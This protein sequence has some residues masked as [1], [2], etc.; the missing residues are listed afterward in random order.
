MKCSIRLVASL[1]IGLSFVLNGC[2]GGGGGE[3]GTE[4]GP[5]SPLPP[6]ANDQW[7]LVGAAEVGMDAALLSRAAS[8]LPEASQHGLASMLVLRHGKPV[9]EQYWNGYGKDHLHDLRS[10]TKSITSLMMGVAIDQ[11]MVNGV[12]DPVANYLGSLYPNAPALQQ[13]IT[14]E[15]MLTMRNGL[16]CDDWVSASPGNESKMYQQ[17]DWVQ[18]VLN[19]PS[20]AAP[21]EVTRYCTGNPVTLGR[22]IAQ[23]SKRT[24]PEF[25][26]QFLF[27]PLGITGAVWAD[28]DEHRQT[29][30]G[31]HIRMRP[32][33][34]AKL[35]QLALNNGLWDGKQL[36]SSAWIQQ[37]T[38]LHTRFSI[39]GERN[40]YG[41]LWWRSVEQVKGK[42]YEMFFASGNGGQYIFVV[43]ALDIVAVFTG[44]NYNSSKADLPFAILDQYILAAVL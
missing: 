38:R 16:A 21:G 39:A 28:F 41:Y 32:R 17:T 25:A 35:G 19:L 36:L 42:D 11:R 18:F 31:G 2:G 37:S 6:N 4:S 14:L 30:T 8:A 24:V 44:E 3:G 40:G 29:D 5:G 34:M 10:A 26:N 27:G 23:A 13:G 43:P 1:V 33:D 12:G 7:T 22:V 15:H 9:L 20:V